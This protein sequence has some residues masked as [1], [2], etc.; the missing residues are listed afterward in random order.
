[1]VKS[2]IIRVDANAQ[3]G[4]GH[5]MRCLALAQA[6]KDAGNRAIFITNCQSD[7]L[8]QQLREE[9]FNLHVL[10]RS[11][12]DPSD[13]DCTKDIL[14]SYPNA[15]VVLD[16]Y[17]FDEAYQQRLKEADHH[18]LVIDDMAHLNHYYADIVLNQNLHAEQLHYSCEPY[19]HLLLGTHYVLLRHEFLAWQDWKREIPDVARRVLVTMGGGDPENHTL[20]VIKALRKIDMPDLEVIGV[21]G[22]SNPHLDLLESAIKQSKIPIRLICNAGNMA[23]LMAWADVA[24]SSSGTTVW[25]LLFLGTPIQVSIVADNQRYIAERI[26]EYGAGKNLGWIGNISTKSLAKA[27]ALLLR[28]FELR[29]KM[30][31]NAKQLVDGLGAQRVVTSILNTRNFILKFRTARQKDCQ[32]LWEWANDPVVR[33]ASFSTEPSTWENHVR[34]FGAKLS[35]PNC[36]YYLFLNQEGVPIGQV[37]FDTSGDKTEISI[38]IAPNFRGAGFGADAIRIASKHLFQET[39]I[40]RIY[41]QIKPSNSSSINAFRKAGYHTAGIKSVKGHRALQMVLDK[42]K[43]VFESDPH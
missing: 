4:T 10:A 30:S 9:E 14:A 16:G 2:L 20:K 41:A 35:D 42:N 39:A 19:T 38:S 12:P 8:L 6:W 11:H 15:W 27:I 31:E 37:R 22:A 43:E 36:H 7:G 18:L 24:V 25:E 13:W 17:H 5:F 3:M 33:A 29:T 26:E 34:W 28:N 32:L 40:T 21:V 23:E 1:M